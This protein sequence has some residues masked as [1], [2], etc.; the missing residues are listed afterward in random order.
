MYRHCWLQLYLGPSWIKI[1]I[2]ECSFDLLPDGC[3]REQGTHPLFESGVLVTMV[4]FMMGRDGISQ[5]S[6]PGIDFWLRWSKGAQQRTDAPRTWTSLPIRG[7]EPRSQRWERCM[8][9]TYTIS[10]VPHLPTNALH[11]SSHGQPVPQTIHRQN[12]LKL[13]L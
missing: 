7:V 3:A 2:F 10:D 9:T 12:S 4:A 8:I 6:R 11:T 1:L 5:W 13:L